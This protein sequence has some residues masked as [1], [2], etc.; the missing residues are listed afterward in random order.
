MKKV[1]SEKAA[2]QNDDIRPEYDLKKLQGGVQGKYY[3]AYRKGHTVKIHKANGTVSIQYFQ[4]GE[5]SVLLEPEVR[6]YFPD[7]DAV[8]NALRCLIPLM[9]SKRGLKHGKRLAA[10]KQIS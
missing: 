6:K 1:I 3:K 4:P 7:A 9:Q 10:S 5:G 8:N 2:L